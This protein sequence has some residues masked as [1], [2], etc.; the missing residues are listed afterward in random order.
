MIVDQ[1]LEFPECDIVFCYY[2]EP[3]RILIQT[4]N[5]SWPIFPYFSVKI[6]H[7][8]NELVDKSTKSAYIARR[9]MCIY[10]SIFTD[11]EK[12]IVFENYLKWS[13]IWW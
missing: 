1:F 4:M 2:D 12:V 6:F 9:W 5:D 10:T 13:V 7:L 11:D 3:T 8:C